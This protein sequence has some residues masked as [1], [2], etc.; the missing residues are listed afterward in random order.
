MMF[1]VTTSAILAAL[2]L[3]SAPTAASAQ[4]FG[5][6]KVPYEKLD[7]KI[8]KT[9]HFDIYFYPEE[10]AAAAMAGRMAERWRARL[11]RLLGHQLSGRQ[12]LVLFASHPHFEQTNV[13]EGM[14]DPSTGG[15]TEGLRRRM[16]LPFAATL[17]D[18]DH[19]IGH[20]LVHAFQYDMLS[21]NVGAVPLWFIEGMAEYLSIGPV[22]VHTAMWLRDAALGGKFPEIKD[23]DN[24]R[25]FPYRFGHAF[26]AFI[27]GK[28]G[29]NTISQIMAAL[30][31]VG[32]PGQGQGPDPLTAI[33]QLTGRDL[34]T[35]SAE[36]KQSVLQLYGI[37][38]ERSPARSARDLPGVIGNRTGSGRINIGPSV[39]P[40]G[41]RVAFLSERGKLSIEAYIADANTGRVLHKLTETAVDPHFQ[42]LQFLASAGAWSPKGDRIA[43]GAV[44]NGRPVIAIL[45]A[46]DGDIVS[47]IKFP[48]IG[49][50][51]QPAWSPD[52]K[53]IAFAG[54]TGGLS[55]LWVHDIETGQSKRLTSDPFADLQPAWS[56]DG[57]QLAWVTDR[58]TSN[59][60]QLSFGDYRIALLDVATGEKRMLETTL[61]G[62]QVNPQWSKDGA[63]VY[64]VANASGTQEVYRV[65]VAGGAPERLTEVNTGVTGIT[66]L[67]PAMSISA[68]ADRMAITLF[69]EGGYDIHLLK[70]EPNAFLEE[71]HVKTA[72]ELPPVVGR[73]T[74]SV[75][76]E[77][78]SKPE[79]GLPPAAQGEVTEYK[80]GLRLLSIGQ[81]LGVGAGGG[82]GAQVGGGI[83]LVFSDML[84]DRLLGVDF[85]V[86]G[87]ARD[88]GASTFYLNREHRW[89][90]GL[91]GEH[92]PYTSGFARAGVTTI[93]GQ[94][95]FVEELE[96]FRQTNTQGGLMTAYPLSRASR[97]EFSGSARH[98]G[99]SREVEQRFFEFP[100]GVFLGEDKFD[101]D[102]PAGI[103]LVET[104]AAF[105]RDTSAFGPV[106]P[107][108]GQ[109]IRVELAPTFGDI[110][111]NNFTADIRQYYM[112]VT[113]VTIALRGLHFGR[114]GTG[115]E[116][117]RLTP[118]FIGYSTLVR[119]YD[120]N[121]FNASECN[122][123]ATSECPEF[124]RLIGSRIIVGNVEVRAPA[125]GLFKRRLE[126]GPLPVE[127][128]GFADAGLAWTRAE[129]PDFAGG[130]RKWVTSAGI[131]A[132]V[133]VFGYLIAEFNLARPFDRNRG[134]MF[135][136]NLRPGF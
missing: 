52:G 22:S 106:S 100:S 68:N 46:D 87:G 35:L 55:D 109:R 29:D 130:T 96:I 131:G 45:D 67:S 31:M 90:W 32:P 132:R 82:F 11:V 50:I 110:R 26:W 60:D 13:V 118:L 3:F 111:M 75:V 122:P 10:E 6:N 42:S 58:F 72:A 88:I 101:L 84:G 78:L 85:L 48:A 20:E 126:Y 1:R 18:T 119:G 27:G 12:P 114:Y 99:F 135:V 80:S 113:P 34:K 134:W 107:L 98:I 38:A 30:T 133:N 24:P 17:G 83:S 86:N 19:V 43:F 39:S 2:L 105:V 5:Q 76:A 120:I 125:F 97:V 108:R 59:L 23:L 25:Y 136:F 54:Q 14:I 37:D 91:M 33:E 112:P 7:F 102:A 36:W 121:S 94:T 47:E 127:I 74:P 93:N 123:T 9:E 129:K 95:V 51:F 115:G 116:D 73:P 57:K 53:S 64:F 92:V 77:L 71:P 40:D 70:A 61:S 16:A 56:A 49:E 15:V 103:N 69:R 63:L 81:A 44:R 66:D 62:D 41:S 28:F 117:S 79:Q 21:R 128:Y 8:L 65:P 104:G 124:D 4:Y 89:Y